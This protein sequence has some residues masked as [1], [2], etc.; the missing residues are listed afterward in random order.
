MASVPR[1]DS[2]PPRTLS[3]TFSDR[4]YVLTR[5]RFGLSVAGHDHRGII[6]TAWVRMLHP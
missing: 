6:P 4:S 5:L 1:K 3:S 2:P